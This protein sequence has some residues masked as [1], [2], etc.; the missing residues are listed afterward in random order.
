MTEAFAPDVELADRLFEELAHRTRDGEGITRPSYSREENVAHD[1]VRGA[2][3]QLGLRTHADNAGNLYMELPGGDRGAPAYVI[4][5]HLDSVKCGGNFDG[6][7]GVLAGLAIASAYQRTGRKPPRPLVVLATRAEESTWFACSYIGARAALGTLDPSLPD[8]VRRVDTGRT[9]RDHAAEC[10]FSLHGPAP[11]AAKSAAAFFEVHIEQGPQLDQRRIPV[12]IVTGIRGNF[13]YRLARCT[14]E[15]GHCGTVPRSL[16]RDA[17]V[18][19]ADLIHGLDAVWE[20]LEGEGKDLAITCGV[21][22]TDGQQH[23]V[24]K[25]AG[26]V[27]FALDVRSLSSEVL[28]DMRTRLADAIDDVAKRRRVA[29]DLG[30][31]SE[32]PPAIM[33]GKL[34]DA[35][36]LAASRQRIPYLEMPSGA[37]HDAAMFSQAG[38]PTAMVFIRNA[39]GSHNPRESMDLDDFRSAASV[40]L[41]TIEVHGR[42]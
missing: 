21:V 30:A 11:L 34:R 15:Y 39:N 36:A 37:G 4:G 25:I 28:S 10:G 3:E 12:G 29:F 38:V 8:Q 33:D 9:L 40:L 31:S 17:V 27:R 23:G 32:A 2:G 6:A 18:A 22:Q 16:R 41:N 5:S 20:A 7:A 26:D 24:S 19:V 14:G 35:L 1:I 42:S 13:R